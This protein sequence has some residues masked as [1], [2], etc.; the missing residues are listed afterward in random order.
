MTG[1]EN[2]KEFSAEQKKARE[3][4]E[5]H[6]KKNNRARVLVNNNGDCFY[7]AVQAA[8]A[9]RYNACELRVMIA[10]HIHRFWNFF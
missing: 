10:I 9:S 5:E 7:Q 4:Y 2:A 3:L 8:I 6:L 1:R